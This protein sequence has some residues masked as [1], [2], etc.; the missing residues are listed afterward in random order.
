MQDE[1]KQVKASGH[2]W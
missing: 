1:E 2:N